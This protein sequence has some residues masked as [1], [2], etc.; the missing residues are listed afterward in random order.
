M[1][2]FN[3]A[4]FSQ[5][6]FIGEDIRKQLPKESADFDGVNDNWKVSLDSFV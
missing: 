3:H 5:N 2:A 1:I 6:I 4:L